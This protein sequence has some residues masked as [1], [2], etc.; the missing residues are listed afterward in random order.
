MESNYYISESQSG[1]LHGPGAIIIDAHTHTHTHTEYSQMTQ[2]HR[3]YEHLLLP[4]V[5]N[6]CL[7]DGAFR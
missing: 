2:T 4:R 7:C 3:E 6:T 5:G 1:C